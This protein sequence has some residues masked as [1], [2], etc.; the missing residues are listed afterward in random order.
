VLDS[1]FHK[2]MILACE[3][4]N[5]PVELYVIN[6][7]GY[8]YGYGYVMATVLHKV[9]ATKETHSQNYLEQEGQFGQCQHC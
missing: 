6:G 3:C 9:S 8:G 4:C 5:Q 7:Y 2:L 1:P